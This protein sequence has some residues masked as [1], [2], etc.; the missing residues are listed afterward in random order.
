[1]C[2]RATVKSYAERTFRREKSTYIHF[3]YCGKISVLCLE[4]TVTRAR[5]RLLVAAPALGIKN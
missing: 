4:R 2:F 5:H 1:M 3:P